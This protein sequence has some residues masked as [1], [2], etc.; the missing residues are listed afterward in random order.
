MTL[1]EAIKRI[2]EIDAKF[3]AAHSWG[4]WMIMAA[5]ERESLAN[6]F[7]LPHRWRARTSG[8]RRTG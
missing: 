1:P 4:S 7:N 6:Q 5:N 8:G 3:E 2:A